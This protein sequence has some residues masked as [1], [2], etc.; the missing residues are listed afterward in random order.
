WE[1][2]GMTHVY[3]QRT[4]PPPPPAPPEVAPSRRRGETPQTGPLDLRPR[5]VCHR[6]PHSGAARRG[7]GRLGL[8]P[9]THPAGFCLAAPPPARTAGRRRP[10]ALPPPRGGP[11]QRPPGGGGDKG[12]APPGR[13]D[14]P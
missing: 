6:H 14:T 4:A 5:P 12:T 3:L 7:G 9:L 2:R 11:R 10:P 1:G 13:P 8:L